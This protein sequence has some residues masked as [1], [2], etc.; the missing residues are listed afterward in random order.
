MNKEKIIEVLKKWNF[1][2]K[3]YVVVASSSLVLHGIKDTTNDIDISVSDELYN[4]LLNDYDCHFVELD[5]NGDAIYRIDGEIT[6]E[7]DFGKTFYLEDKDIIDG[8]QTQT[9]ENIIKL[10][11]KLNRDKDIK[12]I[13]LINKYLNE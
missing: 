4:K 11:Q 2:S 3:D 6:D 5:D 7:L 10:K 8:I 9:L 1:N 13:E 12:D